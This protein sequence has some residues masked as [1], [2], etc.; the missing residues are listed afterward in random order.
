MAAE[1]GASLRALGFEA[2]PND[3]KLRGCLAK[4]SKVTK[5]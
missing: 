1:A 4:D 3:A 5:E 2:E